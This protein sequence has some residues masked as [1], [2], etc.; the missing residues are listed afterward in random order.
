MLVFSLYVILIPEVYPGPLS[1]LK[2]LNENYYN[3]VL[4]VVKKTV[5]QHFEI[6]FNVISFHSVLFLPLFN[7]QS[8]L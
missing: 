2:Y 4:S 1:F 7:L 5:I 3:L 6:E 8:Q